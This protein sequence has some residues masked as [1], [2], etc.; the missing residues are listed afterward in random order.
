MIANEQLQM[1]AFSMLGNV[2][3]ELSF[4]VERLVARVA[5]ERPITFVTSCVRL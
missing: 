5:L 2:R 1:F 4:L 3:F